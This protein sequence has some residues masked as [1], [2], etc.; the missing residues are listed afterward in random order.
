M[1]W[2]ICSFSYVSLSLCLSFLSLNSHTLSLNYLYGA[3][4]V[5]SLFFLPWNVSSIYYL[6][7]SPKMDTARF[8]LIPPPAATP[9]CI[10]A[11]EQ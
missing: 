4:C 10:D 5:S 11:P 9:L 2:K 8:L 7:I 6:I 1:E 3:L